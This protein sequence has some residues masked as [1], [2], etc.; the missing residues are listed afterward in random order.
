MTRTRRAQAL[1]GQTATI[2]VASPATFSE[3]VPATS[4]AWTAESA[5]TAVPAC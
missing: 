2:T 4:Y 3:A 5:K 1:I